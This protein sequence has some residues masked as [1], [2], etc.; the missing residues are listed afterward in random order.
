MQSWKLGSRFWPIPSNIF[1]IISNG[2]PTTCIPFGDGRPYGLSNDGT[3]WGATIGSK[4]YVGDIFNGRDGWVLCI[5][6]GKVFVEPLVEMV[7]LQLMAK[8]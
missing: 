5:I 4:I 3:T 6:N 2:I 1:C 8:F 7:E